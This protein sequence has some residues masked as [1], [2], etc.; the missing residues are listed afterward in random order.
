HAQPPLPATSSSS[1]SFFSFFFLFIDSL[2]LSCFVQSFGSLAP[3]Q[4]SLFRLHAAHTPAHDTH[5]YIY[6]HIKKL[7]IV[8][9][10][11]IFLSYCRLSSDLY[12]SELKL[13]NQS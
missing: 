11:G 2:F 4:S 8:Q 9:F 1:F 13:L 5:T 12:T 6:T 3:P 10:V 7:G